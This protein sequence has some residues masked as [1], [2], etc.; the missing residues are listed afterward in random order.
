MF[1]GLSVAFAE[2]GFGQARQVKAT[3]TRMPKPAIAVIHG[4][5][6]QAPIS[7][8]NSAM[9]PLNPGRPIEAMAA[10]VKSRRRME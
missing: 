4:K 3:P 7:I 5:A 6:R 2:E 10:R 1:R 9:K 8:W